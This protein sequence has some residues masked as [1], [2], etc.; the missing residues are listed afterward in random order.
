MQ[1]SLRLT[2]RKWSK[3]AQREFAAGIIF[4]SPWIIGVLAF[5]AYPMVASLY[6]S[7]SEFNRILDP[8]Q[9]VGLENYIA[10]FNDRLFPQALSNSA[11]LA[12]IGIPIQ[13]AF[14]LLCALLLN[15]KVR[16]Q[17]IWRTI[18]VLPVLMPEV[19]LAILWNWIMNPN[20]GLVNNALKLVG[21]KGPLWFTS[22]LWSKPSILI[23]QTWAVGIMIVLYLAAL[24]GVPQ[25]LYESAEMDGAGTLRR[26]WHIT[27]PM[28]SPVTLFQLITS[29]TWA[30]QYFAQVYILGTIA[31]GGANM[32]SPQGS[33]LLYGLYLYIQAFEYLKMGYASALAW[34]LFFISAVATW[35]VLRTSSRW[36]YYDVT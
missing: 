3:S 18:Y 7:F 36:T 15:L 17:A 20:L 19:V 26:F 5:L 9:W 29:I 35:A 28:I 21:I 30:L 12:V 10:M 13:L 16:G 22:P 6:Y 25:E 31:G 4:S 11:Y 2:G 24:Q 8:P 27:I 32:G 14:S 23:M 34:V 1:L 33:L